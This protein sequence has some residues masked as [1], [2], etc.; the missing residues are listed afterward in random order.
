MIDLERLFGKLAITASLVVDSEGNHIG[1]DGTSKS[2]GGPLDLELLLAFRKAAGAVLTTGKT[3][4]MENYRMPSSAALFVLSRQDRDS[5]PL[6]IR[7]ES[8]KLIGSGT[9]SGLES[10][11]K[12]IEQQGYSKI[13]VEFGPTTLVE[14]AKSQQKVRIFVSS[15]SESG[16]QHFADKHNL[17]TLHAIKV[18][19]LYVTEVS[20]RA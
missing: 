1:P 12:D 19:Y 2:L 3:A 13:H 20:G 18:D 9:S 10:A 4:R 5:L 7:S 15:D 6:A 16:A 14:M 17:R 8:A 11:F